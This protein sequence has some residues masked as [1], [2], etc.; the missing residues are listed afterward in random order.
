MKIY[1]SE[2]H[3]KHINDAMKDG[4]RLDMLTAASSFLEMEM[5]CRRMLGEPIGVGSSRIVFQI[6]DE[7]CLKL[8]KNEKGIAQNKEE[9]M[10]AATTK[11]RFI[12]K[13]YNGTDEENGKWI[14]TQYVIPATEMDFR[15]TIG[16]D[17]AEIYNFIYA[18]NVRFGS[19]D[20]LSVAMAE[21]TINSIRAKYSKNRMATRLLNDIY[22]LKKSYNQLIGDASR[23]ENWGMALENGR[24]CM[25]ILDSGC[26]EE[27]FNKY[28]RNFW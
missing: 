21:M 17:F 4:F 22:K 25:V 13:I 2:S 8:A 20:R 14:I 18:Q 23:I 7:V 10:I 27:I 5:Y 24:P 28:Y 11:I 12:P 6:D 16:M 19:N 15:K 26:S 9:I 3:V 1:I